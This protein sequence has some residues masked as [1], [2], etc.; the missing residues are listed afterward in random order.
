M[1]LARAL[2]DK[3]PICC[4]VKFP[5]FARTGNET[6]SPAALAEMSKVV[7]TSVSEFIVTA[8]RYLLFVMEMVSARCRLIPVR[9]SN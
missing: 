8:E 2:I 6:S 1:T 5:Q 4:T 7:P 9:D 3:L